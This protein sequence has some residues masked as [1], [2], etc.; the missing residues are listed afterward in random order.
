MTRSAWG[1]A[2]A[3]FVAAVLLLA[4]VLKLARPAEWRAQATGLGVPGL[5]ANVVPFVEIGLGAGLLVQ[6][7]RHGVAWAAAGL[8]AAFTALLGLR[9]AQGQRP[10]CA[11]FGSLSSR[12]IGAAHLVRNA[13]F[14]ALAVL[15]ATL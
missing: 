12:P 1:I 5:L 4:G 15:A 13:V 11:C 9:V 7:Q 3:A 6:W 2:A 8:F 10:P 14:I